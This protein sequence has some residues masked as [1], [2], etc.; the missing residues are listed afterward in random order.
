MN[1]DVTV[2][3]GVA[4][5]ALLS[6]MGVGAG[7]YYDSPAN[8]VSV[9]PVPDGY[10][11][12]KSTENNGE[13]V[14]EFTKAPP[15][16]AI[17]NQTSDESFARYMDALPESEV[18]AGL[19]FKSLYKS[20]QNAQLFA[21][22]TSLM[23]RAKENQAKIAK[24]DIDI[25]VG[26]NTLTEPN[27]EVFGNKEELAISDIKEVETSVGQASDET[28]ET[29]ILKGVYANYDNNN[30]FI[31]YGAYIRFNGKSRRVSTGAVVANNL[32]VVKINKTNIVLQSLTKTRTLEL[33]GGSKG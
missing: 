15:K 30:D 22:Y 7:Y 12:S 3:Q 23:A 13:I 31:S 27:I 28:I 8:N 20:R 25:K 18:V 26:G 5:L 33:E 6:V 29:V 14:H 19:E 2:K 17:P 10:S 4:I 11:K 1:K 16:K 24:S 32:S 21:D 9:A